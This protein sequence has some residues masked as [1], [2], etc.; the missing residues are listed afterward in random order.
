MNHTTNE[1][2]IMKILTT[3][4]GNV[5]APD[6]SIIRF[7]KGLFG[8]EDQKIWFALSR[9]D[10]DSHW[11]WFQSGMNPALAFVIVEPALFFP[12]YR[13]GISPDDAHAIGARSFEHT[14]V[15]AIANHSESLTVNLRAPLVIN[16][17]TRKGVQVLTMDDTWKVQTPMPKMNG[18][19]DV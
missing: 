18:A 14:E 12:T 15:F 11:R 19:I 1:R 3:R 13:V 4:F 16:T 10:D 9:S 8:F 5:E 6:S 7:E 17:Q 2:D